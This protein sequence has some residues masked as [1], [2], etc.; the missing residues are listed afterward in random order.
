MHAYIHTIMCTGKKV[1][2]SCLRGKQSSIEEKIVTV[3][4]LVN[5]L[6]EYQE[7]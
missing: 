2:K 5:G 1:K 4:R 6:G 7:K 3:K